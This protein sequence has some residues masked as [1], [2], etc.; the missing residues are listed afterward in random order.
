MLVEV[1][2]H[3]FKEQYL[4]TQNLECKTEVEAL[5][6]NGNYCGASLYLYHPVC[7]LEQKSL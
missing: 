5:E 3:G 6:N 1:F 2:H 7:I 4:V